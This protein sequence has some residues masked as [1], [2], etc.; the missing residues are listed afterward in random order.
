MSWQ[1]IKGQDILHT[2][3]LTKLL[4]FPF[5][6]ACIL[7]LYNLAISLFSSQ[8]HI[9]LMSSLLHLLPRSGIKWL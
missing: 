5:P 1:Y 4:N 9:C 2:I 3:L 8:F 7:Y 6:S